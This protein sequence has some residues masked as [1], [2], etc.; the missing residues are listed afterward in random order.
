MH[1]ELS[2]AS[3]AIAHNVIALGEAA[4]TFGSGLWVPTAF[5]LV[6]GKQ[7][8]EAC[9]PSCPCSAISL[10]KGPGGKPVVLGQG[11]FGTVRLLCL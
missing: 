2:A 4:H 1:R 5:Q 7:S 6:P 11:G 9:A 3:G 10:T 8:E